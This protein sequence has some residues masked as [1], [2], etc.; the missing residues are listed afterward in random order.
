MDLLNYCAKVN[1]NLLL[2]IGPRPDGTHLKGPINQYP[3]RYGKQNVE[4]GKIKKNISNA[5]G[6][7]SS[8]GNMYTTTH[9][10]WSLKPLQEVGR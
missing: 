2:N 5:V 6:F 1:A 10:S 8:M 4:Y 7:H 9:R 3:L